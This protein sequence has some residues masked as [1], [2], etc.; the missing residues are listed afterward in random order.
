MT[1][2]ENFCII[3]I[4]INSIEDLEEYHQLLTDIHGSLF[5]RNKN[6]W[7]DGQ[8]VLALD[9]CDFGHCLKIFC[10]YED[11]LKFRKLEHKNAS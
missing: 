3:N 7:Y 2:H 4:K 5:I 9:N 6:R 8:D 1:M 10:S 11:A